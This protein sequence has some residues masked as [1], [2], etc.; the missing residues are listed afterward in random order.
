MELSNF[1]KIRFWDKVDIRGEDECWEW[2]AG[3]HRSGYGGFYLNRKTVGAHAV[4]YFLKNGKIP[5][6]EMVLHT[7]DNP[8]CCNHKHL[9]TGNNSKNMK[10]MHL[11]GRSTITYHYGDDH[12]TR[13]YP[14][15]N[16]GSKNGSSLLT[17]LR[18][19]KVKEL[20]KRKVTH[21][22]I[23]TI[24]GVSISC[25]SMISNGSNWSQVNID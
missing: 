4:S 8:P 18:V 7:C 6:G 16:A 23:A 15:M 5:E 22:K 17:E 11:K 13:K 21:S 3:R 24:F 10:D 9:F 2:K 12:W 14:G 1:D 19:R 20:L 25:I